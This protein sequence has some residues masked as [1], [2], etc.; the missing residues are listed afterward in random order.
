MLINGKKLDSWQ[1]QI[2][3]SQY[4]YRW[5]S[6]NINRARFWAGISGAPT[7]PLIS[8]QE[9]INRHAFHFIK[10]GSRLAR[11]RHHAEVSF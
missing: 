3:L 1:K 11:N 8:D 5:T 10:D 7:I 9:W 2:V 4:G 6:G